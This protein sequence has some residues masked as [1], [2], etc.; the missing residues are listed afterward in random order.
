MPCFKGTGYVMSECLER[1]YSKS[2]STH[3]LTKVLVIEAFPVIVT[4]HSLKCGQLPA[5][6][7]SLMGVQ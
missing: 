7:V 5:F 3:L 6:V 1:F 4:K 2:K